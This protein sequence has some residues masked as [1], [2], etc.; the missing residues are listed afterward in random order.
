[1]NIQLSFGSTAV[2]GMLGREVE[3]DIGIEMPIRASLSI[4]AGGGLTCR[5]CASLKQKDDGKKKFIKPN[6]QRQDI[7]I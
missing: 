3:M 7:I 2:V 1:M 6:S 4:T 5:F